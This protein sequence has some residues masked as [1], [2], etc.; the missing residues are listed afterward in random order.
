MRYI[1]TTKRSRREGI[2]VSAVDYAVLSRR[3]VA[4]LEEARREAGRACLGSTSLDLRNVEQARTLPDSGGTVGPL[5][6]G[7][8]IEVRPA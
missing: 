4:T 3:E 5:P 8:V 6:D 1:V 7:T 2:P